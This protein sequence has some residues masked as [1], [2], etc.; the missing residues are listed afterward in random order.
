MELSFYSSIYQVVVASMQKHS[1][2]LISGLILGSRE[3]IEK[4]CIRVSFNGILIY[5]IFELIA[6]RP[7]GG[8]DF[9]MFFENLMPNTMPKIKNFQVIIF[10]S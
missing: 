5:L 3:A 7:L 6:N 9:S 4:Y 8:D 1:N 2:E 10:T